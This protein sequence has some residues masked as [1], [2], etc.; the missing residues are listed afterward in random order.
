MSCVL[1]IDVGGTKVAVA[2]MEG[3]E[4]RQ[5]VEAPTMLSSPDALLDGVESAVREVS[6]EAGKPQAI[7]IGVPSQVD[8]A[9]G[10]VLA[11]VN[12]PLAGLP[13]RQELGTRF[14][15][16]VY[17]DNDA[18]CA[19]L[20]EAQLV[21]DPPAGHLVM[22]TLGTGVGGGVIIDGRI[23]RGASGLGAELGHVVIDGDAEGEQ[24]EGEFPRPGTLEWLCSGRGL[25]R[26]AT[27]RARSDHH[28]GLG[29]LNA[30]KGRVS[31]RD[32]V[33]L[34]QGGDAGA[35]ELFEWHGRWLGRGIAGVVNSFEP[36]Y[37]VIGGG[38][39]RAADLFLDAARAEAARWALPPL[40]QRASVGLARGGAAAGVIGAGLLAAQELARTGDTA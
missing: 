13:L 20:A 8:F 22:L 17:V 7:G 4:V 9:S 1:G 38:L 19:A 14:G 36:R 10:T 39:S 5:A 37:V 29:R 34:A 2:A 12:I 40:W 23:F 11:S 26:E 24:P 35:L 32:A 25:E 33:A 30:E 3:A 6:R 21:P 15:A 31:G 18:N 27:R 28:S 16:P